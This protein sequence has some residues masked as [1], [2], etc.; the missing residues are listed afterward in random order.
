M[1][2]SITSSLTCIP[3]E[4]CGCNDPDGNIH[5]AHDPWLNDNCTVSAVCTNGTYNSEPTHCSNY[6]T[7]TINTD[8]R[9]ACQCDPGF[10]GDGFNCTDINECLDPN[11]CG[12]QQGHGNCTNTI[13][14]YYCTCNHYQTGHDCQNYQPT[15][16]CADWLR[17]WNQTE[18]GVYNIS[19]PE[20]LNRRPAYSNISVYCDMTSCKWWE[21]RGE[22][23]AGE[24]RN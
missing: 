1:D 17:Y 14:S 9:H 16:H 18:D 8:N 19:L 20:E 21:R 12:Q 7:C 5:G 10:T 15:R 11:S 2:N 6:G 24:I 13:G 3:I 4:E 22:G 23:M